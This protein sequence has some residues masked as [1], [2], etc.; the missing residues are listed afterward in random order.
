M[1]N[2]IV[3]SHA[4]A[5][6]VALLDWLTDIDVSA[7]SP[8]TIDQM[9][10]QIVKCTPDIII[11][12]QNLESINADIL[13]HLLHNQ[14]PKAQSIILTDEAPTFEM[15]KNT[16]FSVR[17]YITKEQRSSLAKAVRVIYEGEAWLPR[18]I[19][20]E[21]LNQFAEINTDF[22]EPQLKIVK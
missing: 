9:L 17:G 3:V 5:N 22:N 1:I 2:V 15:L 7:V 6:E 10:Q 16:G 8:S 12:E 13:C 18:T 4:P 21:M 11:I 19:I 14:Y 20:T